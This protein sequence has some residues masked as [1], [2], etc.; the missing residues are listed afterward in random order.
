MRYYSACFIARVFT[1]QSVY[2]SHSVGI[3]SGRCLM[4]LLTVSSY[5]KFVTSQGS[6]QLP[7]F[8]CVGEFMHPV[9]LI[10]QTV[11]IELSRN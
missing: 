11:L 9:Y 3:I 7:I 6:Q 5:G 10:F 4:R 2:L 8:I 1:E